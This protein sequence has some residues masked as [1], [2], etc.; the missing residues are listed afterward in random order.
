[1][2]LKSKVSA[3]LLSLSLVGV[4]FI[5]GWEGT[6]Q[7]AYLDVV[8]VPT[9]CTGSTRAVKIGQTASLGECQERLRLDTQAVGKSMQRCILAPVTQEQ[10]DALLSL[11]FN[12]GGG[13]LCRSTLV[14]KLNAGDCSGAGTEFLRWDMAGGKHLRGLQNRRQAERVV[15]MKGCYEH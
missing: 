1:M 8:G 6:E 10:Y 3:V 7:K 15:F 4:T 9:I 12:I 2:Q 14:R 13:A 11:G 5:Q